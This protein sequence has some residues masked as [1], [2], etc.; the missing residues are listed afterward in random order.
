MQSKHDTA[1]VFCSDEVCLAPDLVSFLSDNVLSLAEF[2][3]DGKPAIFVAAPEHLETAGQ[4]LKQMSVAARAQ[5]LIT[6][7]I[8]KGESLPVQQ[9]PNVALVPWSSEECFAQWLAV[10]QGMHT[11]VV[12]PYWFLPSNFSRHEHVHAACFIQAPQRTPP[13]PLK[14]GIFMREIILVMIFDSRWL[15]KRS[16]TGVLANWC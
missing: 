10:L 15:C 3:P 14:G 2:T 1:I 11:P 4:A 8:F 12:S 16:Q 5:S 9:P 13:C 6:G 7:R